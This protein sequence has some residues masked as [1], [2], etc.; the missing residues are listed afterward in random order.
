MGTVVQRYVSAELTH[1]VGRGKTP[2]EQYELLAHILSEGLLSH[3]PHK[4]GQK[5]TLEVRPAKVSANQMY[6][7]GVVCFCD[8]PRSDFA[9]HMAKYSPFGLAFP[10]GFLIPKGVTPAFYVAGDAPVTG[11]EQPHTW[12]EHLDI[13][14]LGLNETM[15]HSLQYLMGRNPLQRF[16]ERVFFKRA[17]HDLVWPSVSMTSLLHG[18]L[19]QVKVFDGALPEGHVD[20]F[21]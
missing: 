1:F 21:Y 13:A 11:A 17:H 12:G 4:R 9:I 15:R 20:N 8:I 7:P 19:S 10:K 6:N 2:D 3:P 18:F 14:A 5:A 16:V